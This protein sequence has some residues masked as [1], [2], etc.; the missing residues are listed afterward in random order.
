MHPVCIISL[1]ALEYKTEVSVE[2]VYRKSIYK[3]CFT[4][5][6]ACASEGAQLRVSVN[7]QHAA[8][9]ALL[10]CSF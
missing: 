9:R 8:H 10:F 4:K 5:R 2:K 3:N 6:S 7:F 1:S